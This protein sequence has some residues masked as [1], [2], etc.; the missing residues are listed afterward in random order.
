MKTGKPELNKAEECPCHA[1]Q[2]QASTAHGKSIMF[3]DGVCGLCNKSVQFVL[4]NDRADQIVFASLQS[5]FSQKVLN[6]RGKDATKLDTIYVITDYELSG[7]RVLMKSDAIVALGKKLGGWLS[8]GATMLGILPKA[9]RDF[10]Y[11]CVASNRYRNFGKYEQCPLPSP[12]TRKKFIA[13]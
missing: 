2:D 1:D 7:E 12:E 6:E 9:F 3:F 4:K 11:D 10:G 8:V 5:D 13:T